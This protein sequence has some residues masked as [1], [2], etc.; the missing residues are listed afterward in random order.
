MCF[1]V[2]FVV[3]IARRLPIGLPRSF[4][5]SLQSHQ[6]LFAIQ[7]YHGFKSHHPGNWGKTIPLVSMVVGFWMGPSL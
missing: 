1:V 3:L 7:G 4:S 6:H 2:V 5:F